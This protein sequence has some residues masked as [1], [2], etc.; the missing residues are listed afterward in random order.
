MVKEVA[1][2]TFEAV[3]VGH[4]E[5]VVLLGNNTHNR[6]LRPGRTNLYAV[7]MLKGH[8]LTTGETVKFSKTGVLLDGQHRLAAIVQAATAGAVEQA[9]GSNGPEQVRLPANP[10]IAIPM[11][12]IRGLDDAA[13]EAMDT[14]AARGLNDILELNRQEKNASTLATA[15]RVIYS[16]TVGNRRSMGKQATATNTTLL[17]FFDQNADEFRDLVTRVNTRYQRNTHLLSP[18]MLCLTHWV[19]EERDAEEAEFFFDRLYDGQN[20]VKGD[21]IY[22]LRETLVKLSKSR[23]D[24]PFAWVLALVIKAWNAYRSG[25]RLTILSYKMGGRH[26]ENYPE[27]V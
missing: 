17:A 5:A 14:G 16:W 21:P 23:D 4:N 1:G 27:A 26:P 10:K 20:L 18:R 6:K 7:D 19:F 24:K 13:Q 3:Q 9:E 2:L 22:E 15:I 8:W 11:V 12:I 25:E